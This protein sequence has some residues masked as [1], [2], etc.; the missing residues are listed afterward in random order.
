MFSRILVASGVAFMSCWF[1]IADSYKRG[2]GGEGCSVVLFTTKC[3]RGSVRNTLADDKIGCRSKWPPHPRPFSSEDGG[4]GRR[5]LKWRSFEV[6]VQALAASFSFSIQA[7]LKAVRQR[8]T[9]NRQN[10]LTQLGATNLTF[11]NN[12][13]VTTDQNGKTII[14]D[15]WN[16][17]VEQKTVVTS[18][19]AFR[20]GALNR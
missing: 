17:M 19:V 3:A 5:I 15:A 14:Y 9:R 2:V 7:R 4:E 20:Y 12:S 13:N 6:G 8:R 18:N 16:R 10:E 11:D 1:P